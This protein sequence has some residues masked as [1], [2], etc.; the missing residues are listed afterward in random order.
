VQA[1]LRLLTNPDAVILNDSEGSHPWWKT[2]DSS[3]KLSEWQR[4]N[5]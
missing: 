5:I 1:V 4:P 2:W 3:S